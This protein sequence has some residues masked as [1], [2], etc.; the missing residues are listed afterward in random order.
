MDHYTYLAQSDILKSKEDYLMLETLA[1]NNE[2]N[3][4][5]SVEI[6]LINDKKIITG[7]SLP[8]CCDVTIATRKINN[9]FEFGL[10][11]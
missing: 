3:D 1:T 2:N 8:F 5:K 10:T 6:R 9:I 11:F 7:I 4:R